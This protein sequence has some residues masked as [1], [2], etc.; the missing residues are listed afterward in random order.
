MK[1]IYPAPIS[2]RDR[3]AAYRRRAHASAR[4]RPPEPAAT[5]AAPQSAAP[6]S[7]PAIIVSLAMQHAK[8]CKYGG[9]IPAPILDELRRHVAAGNATCRLVAEWIER[10]ADRRGPLR[11]VCGGEL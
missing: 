3:A 9:T 7:D 4:L 1:T 10:R 5:D 6:N 2:P 11:P 8:L